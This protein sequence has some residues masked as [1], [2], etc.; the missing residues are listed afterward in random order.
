MG[1]HPFIERLRV[2]VLFATFIAGAVLITLGL[3]WCMTTGA[4]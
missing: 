1:K 3:L 2:V 4:G